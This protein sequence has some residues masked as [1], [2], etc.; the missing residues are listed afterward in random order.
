[1]NPQS[2]GRSSKNGYVRTAESPN[3]V[4]IGAGPAG[5]TAAYEL[6]QHD[7][8]S[9]ILEADS[10][11]GG[12]ARTV[13]YKGYLF[14]IGGH[15]FFTKVSLIEN[16][17]REVLGDDLI[18][19]SRR[20]RIY[21]KKRFFAYPIEP[22]RAL[23][24]L[25]L[26]E[27]ARCALSYLRAKA[28]KREPEDDFATWVSNRFGKRLF[29]IFFKTYTEKVWG[30][31]CHEIK[32]EW[33]AQRIK[34]LSLRTLL[35][36][37]FG[38]DADASK[39][40]VI[41]TLIP[42]FLYPLRGP[43]MMW[44]KTRSLIE[45]RG[46]KV[47]TNAPVE[48]IFWKPGGIESVAAGGSLHRGT[49]FISSLPIRDL[50]QRLHPAPPEN[51]LRAAEDFHYRD[52]LT[53]ALI[54]KRESVFPDHW[55]YVH[56][57]KVKLGRIQNYKNWSPNMVPDPK[58]TCLGLE[59]FCSEGD[60]LWN[61]PDDALIRLASEELASLGLTPFDSVIDGTVVRVRKAYPVYDATYRRGL[62]TIQSFLECVPNL[63]LVGRN[64]M[65]R[66]NN[67]DHS[68][69]TAILAA[70]NI[71]GAQHDLWNVNADYEYHEEGAAI[72]EEEI[73]LWKATQPAVPSRIG[74]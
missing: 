51:V 48:K 37:A 63:Q 12:L 5:L 45:Q 22:A 55:I 21:Y 28:W 31:P 74:N 49:H 24:N 54:V 20:S 11:V 40:R 27:S 18:T 3:V 46:C 72:T 2:R 73:R 61:M 13:H 29:Q 62:A 15:R 58:T 68:M 47:V 43:G 30:M 42:E 64:G 56:D 33:A 65:H 57:P 17:W 41:K 10:V 52:F 1:M 71:L 69:L 6:S 35:R 26:I 67:Q 4:V 23:M 34:G 7:V 19:R 8:R 36:N 66:Y 44:E 9:T 50:I 60:D 53:V 59:Y 25:G 39:N 70:R 16:L 14:D 32:A 38:R